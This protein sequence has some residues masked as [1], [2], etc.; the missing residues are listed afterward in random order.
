MDVLLL[1]ISNT[2][3][4]PRSQ[5]NGIKIPSKW[6]LYEGKTFFHEGEDPLGMYTYSLIAI[7]TSP[8]I[9][10]IETEL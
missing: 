8:E 10:I 7:Q 4:F 9:K 1:L 5:F 3:D 2:Y 6:Y